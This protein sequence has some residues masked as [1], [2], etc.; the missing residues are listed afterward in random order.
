MTIVKITD[1][2]PLPD[3]TAAERNRQL[4]QRRIGATELYTELL[5]EKGKLAPSEVFTYK[6]RL[7]F[8]RLLKA[9]GLDGYL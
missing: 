4:M 7:R 5:R 8:H 3:L 6:Q 1:L 9:A 2:L